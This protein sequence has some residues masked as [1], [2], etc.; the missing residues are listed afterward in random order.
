MGGEPTLPAVPLPSSPRVDREHRLLLAAVR[1]DE[2]PDTLAE[3]PISLVADALEHA[4]PERVASGR[5][6]AARA[7]ALIDAARQ[8]LA[9]D[10]NRSLPDLAGTL[11]VSPHHL[12][13]TF[14]AVTGHTVSRHRMRL[15]ARAALERL[16]GGDHKLAQLA[17]DVGFV[18]QSHLCR[19]ILGETGDAPLR[20]P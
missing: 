15:R 7:L 17:A 20:P 10:P 5:P 8:C 16:A 18:D 11:H 9:A 3:R 1:R 14:R 19:V 6:S 4:D 2:S 13:R 12:S